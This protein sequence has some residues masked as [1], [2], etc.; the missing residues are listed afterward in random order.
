M[1]G[2]ERKAFLLSLVK[3]MAEKGSWCGE[4]HIQK[5]VFFLDEMLKVPTSF[6]FILY[7]HGPF[8]F[9]LRDE[10]TAMRADRIL[11]LIIPADKK[12]GSSLRPGDLADKV[13]ELYPKASKKYAEKIE[14]IASTVAWKSVAE[15]ERLST[16]LFLSNHRESK[17]KDLS[18][19]LNQ[20]K[21]HISV[22]D[23]K[24]AFKEV[25]R[26]KHKANR[27]VLQN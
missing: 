16:A 13:E 9:E 11:E 8:S 20:L 6:E 1:K 22:E 15:L 5:S 27:E 2:I 24:I 12:Y 3:R 19:Y 14:F 25:K 4:T 26:L 7:I 18:R 21:P 17:G 10:L 23:A